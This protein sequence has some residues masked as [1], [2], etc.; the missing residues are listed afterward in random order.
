MRDRILEERDMFPIFRY[1]KRLETL[2]KAIGFW[3]N[4]SEKDC[5][6]MKEK[7]K[8]MKIALEEEKGIYLH[9]IRREFSKNKDIVLKALEAFEQ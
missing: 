1:D 8:Q 4:K 9:E 2:K 6:Q 3:Y 5:K 7:V